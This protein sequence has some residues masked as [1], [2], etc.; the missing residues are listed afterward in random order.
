MTRGEKLLIAQYRA[1]G[2]G[3]TAI[4]DA[5]GMP[6][7]TVKS[8]CQRNGLGKDTTV[9]A[10]PIP[11]HICRQCGEPLEQTAHRKTRRFCS[12]ACRLAWWHTHRDH[13]RNAKQHVYPACQKEF[14][15][16]RRQ[17][18]CS[19]ACYIRARFGRKVCA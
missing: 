12:D 18:Y 5:L 1:Q 17:T 9:S 14:A 7:N 16:D 6:K 19:H 15:T 2:M 8:F 10:K 11:D 3:Y 13:G 4:A